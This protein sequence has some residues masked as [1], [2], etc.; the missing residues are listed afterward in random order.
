MIATIAIALSLTLPTP[1]AAPPT[2]AASLPAPAAVRADLELPGTGGMNYREKAGDPVRL[3]AYGLGTRDTYLRSATGNAF[4]RQKTLSEV[5]VS[6]GGRLAAGVPRAYRSGHDAL[7]VTDRATGE[8]TTIRTVK[9]PMTASYASW[10]RDGRQVALTVE[11]KVSGTWR[12]LGFAVVDVAAKTA[13]TVRI[14]GLSANAG[15]WWSP[16]GRLVSR[17]GAGLRVYRA[18]DG[19]VMRTYADAGPPTGP[20]DAFSPS[21]K[22]LATWC[23]ER[24][25]E[26]L[27]L[28]DSATG[29]V[30]AR[31]GAAP[32]A[33]WGWWDDEHV[34]AVLAHEDAYRL[35][36]LDLK[37][38]VTRVL[39][40]VPA[41]T[42]DADLWLSFV[43]TSPAS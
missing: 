15:F 1:I 23:P 32:R 25:R 41:R 14:A 7:L 42:W 40:D 22:R 4:A 6:P 39:A 43:R 36:V 38:K 3:T 28:I 10:S 17:H 20:E 13:R 26:Q 5:S 2:P 21:G 9:K 18:S 8:T 24:F 35:A 27:C 11:Q 31:V 37:G 29:K 33:V 12:V 19:A 30:A 16:D 34:I